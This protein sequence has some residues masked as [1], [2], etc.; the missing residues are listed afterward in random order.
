[1]NYKKEYKKYLTSSVLDNANN[2][3][4]STSFI[5][6]FAV[7]L[8]LSDF[9]IGIYAVLD[10]ITNVLQILAAPLFSRIGQSNME[11][12]GGVLTNTIIDDYYITDYYNYY[13]TN[14]PDGL[15]TLPELFNRI[16]TFIDDIKEKYSDKNILLVT[17]GAVART[18]KY[19]FEPLPEDGLILNTCGQ[20]NCEVK[21]YEL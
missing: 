4:A 5:S 2:K 21:E 15:E 17:H 14:I 10:T 7:Y 9:A 18:I 13:S 11:R 3:I 8:G 6:A 19:Y 16:H 12:D 20:K 1:M